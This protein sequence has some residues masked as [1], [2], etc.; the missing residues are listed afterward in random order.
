MLLASRLPCCLV[1][2]GKNVLESQTMETADILGLLDQLGSFTPAD[3]QRW[4]ESSDVSGS[5][6]IVVA[7]CV[8]LSS[9]DPHGPRPPMQ[10]IC[11][12]L[13]KLAA[14]KNQTGA[15]ALK[16]IAE[17]AKNSRMRI[18]A[19][20][21]LGRASDRID[22]RTLLH[23]VLTE[24]LREYTN[25]QHDALTDRDAKAA[26]VE[27]IGGLARPLPAD[28]EL[29]LSVLLPEAVTHSYSDVFALGVDALCRIAGPRHLGRLV[30][31]AGQLAGTPFGLE[32]LSVCGK[33]GKKVLAPH[34]EQLSQALSQSLARPAENNGRLNVL[35]ERLCNLAQTLSCK[36]LIQGLSTMRPDE[37]YDTPLGKVAIA[38]AT[39]YERL[40]EVLV[41]TCVAFVRSPAN[42]RPESPWVGELKRCV[43]GGFGAKIVRQVIRVGSPGHKN[44]LGD[45][46]LADI[47]GGAAAFI[48]TLCRVVSAE[49]GLSP[50]Q[51]LY[52][53]RCVLVRCPEISQ[54][55]PRAEYLDEF[56]KT[57]RDAVEDWVTKLRDKP[58]AKSPIHLL[59]EGLFSEDTQKGAV[60]IAQRLLAH[61][62]GLA[63][64]ILE[65]ILS[66]A[67]R[68]D[69]KKQGVITSLPVFR[70]FEDSLFARF[71]PWFQRNLTGSACVAGRINHYA[72][73]VAQRR[74]IG[75]VAAAREAVRSLRRLPDAEYVLGLLASCKDD[76]ST[77]LLCEFVDFAGDDERL[78]V[79][80]RRRAIAAVAER[81]TSGQSP[82]AARQSHILERIHGRFK[83]LPNVRRAAYEACGRIMGFDSIRPLRERLESENQPVC[84]KA[85]AGVLAKFRDKL[86]HNRPPQDNEA[87]TVEW[88]EHLRNLRD[89]TLSNQLRRFLNP[90]HPSE[91]V[92]L[93]ALGT[94]E[95]LGNKDEIA[96]LDQFTRNTAPTGIVLQ[97]VRR[98]K[99]RLQG[100]SDLQLF[101]ALAS[102]FDEDSSVLDPDT[103]YQ[104]LLGTRTQR[105]A[106][107]LG[108]TWKQWEVGHWDDFVTHLDACC[109]V[110]IRHLF[111]RAP[112]SMKMDVHK[113][114]TLARKPY[115]NLLNTSEFREGL[116]GLQPAFLQI[117]AFRSD[118]ATA[119]AEDSD[120]QAKPGITKEGAG[121]A[122]EQFRHVFPQYVQELLKA[123]ELDPNRQSLQGD[124]PQDHGDC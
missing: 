13:D 54:V 60:A 75:F 115:A 15:I 97:T 2:C 22:V 25:F 99:V 38:A 63:R 119:H 11:S 30:E 76:D 111:E 102:Y 91:R 57:H 123:S 118:A 28:A 113:A 16:R 48:D 106:A 92:L 27:A 77:V 32:V 65:A 44:I 58:G 81:I 105:L 87:G 43:K 100:R 85:I 61:E 110:L 101:E 114:Q 47:L 7:A 39:S 116:P 83:D 31:M 9:I 117:H 52:L 74:G 79:Y 53:M 18:E 29:I 6:A 36:A 73:D 10:Q 112:Q 26:A 40:D 55:V 82:S 94:L 45:G 35:S 50:E 4:L 107:R 93:A 8:F 62:D 70:T 88:I 104:R 95:S 34:A 68:V 21:R 51:L 98:A 46:T 71:Q 80:V 67:A 37:G 122:L 23:A 108:E 66:S 20:R 19:I 49:P 120:G 5:G 109:E 12:A 69:Q 24:G 72:L 14:S 124:A 86:L 1:H 64:F 59:A 121:L 17:T 78:T 84:R 56:R 33:Y 3:L 42:A 90:P 41:D 103:D 96:T 89:S